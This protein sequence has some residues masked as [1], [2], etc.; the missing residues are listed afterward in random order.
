MKTKEKIF[1]S[2]NFF[3]SSENIIHQVWSKKKVKK[4]KKKAKKQKE[5]FFKFEFAVLIF[6]SPHFY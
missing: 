1:H 2:I 5:E 3:S 6:A 4:T